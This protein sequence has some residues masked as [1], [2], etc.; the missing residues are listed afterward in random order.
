MEYYLEDSN[1][2]RRNTVTVIGGNS[3]SYTAVLSVKFTDPPII[4]EPVTPAEVKTWCAIDGTDYDSII[5]ILIS[6]ARQMVEDYAN[7]SLID[8][9]IK[10]KV[11]AGTNLPYGGT[12]LILNVEDNDGNSIDAEYQELQDNG[13]Y[14]VTYNVTAI[15]TAKLKAAVLQQVVFMYENRGDATAEGL[16]PMVKSSLKSLRFV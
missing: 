10:A 16:S 9:K 1:N 4:T 5:T 14:T 2:A 15:V 12:I 7:L 3:I 11:R 13:E 8:R 6:A